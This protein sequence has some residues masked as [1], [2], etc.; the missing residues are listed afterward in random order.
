MKWFNGGYI[1]KV[2]ILVVLL[3]LLKVSLNML[4]DQD[5]IKGFDPYEILEVAPGSTEQ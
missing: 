2:I 5:T 3:L 1:V 4:P